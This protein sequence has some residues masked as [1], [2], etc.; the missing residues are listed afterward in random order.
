MTGYD[1]FENF[2][3]K[4]ICMENYERGDWMAKIVFRQYGP[5]LQIL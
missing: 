2:E 1:N 3:F 4:R 5:L